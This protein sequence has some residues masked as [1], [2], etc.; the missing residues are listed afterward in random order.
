[1]ETNE[2][3]SN[4]EIRPVLRVDSLKKTFSIVELERLLSFQPNQ[5]FRSVEAVRNINL[6]VLPGEVFGFLGPNGAGKTTTI[7][8]CMDLI[9]PTEGHIQLFG[10]DPR[11][12]LAKEK[13]G[14]LPEHP[15]FYDYLKP[16]EILDY[17]GRVFGISRQDRKKKINELLDRVGLNHA[18]N[19]PLRKFSKGMLQRLGIAQAII[20]EPKL[21]VLDEPLSGLDPMGRKEIRDII[22]EQRSKGTTIFFSSHILSDIEHLCDRVAIVNHGEIVREGVLDTLLSSGQRQS[23]M[24]VRCEPN[25]LEK[26]LHF[27]EIDLVHLGSASRFVVDSEK[28]TSVIEAVHKAG[29]MIESLQP[30]R[31]SLEDLFVR[32]TGGGEA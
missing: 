16:Q 12:R 30:H 7:K 8:M 24:V 9:E 5:V 25:A 6:S 31:D 1:M 21:L 18:R 10:Q 17:F 3:S 15:Y 20:N 19:R 27:L 11:Q 13:V 14:Y 26:A 29:G 23:E 4:E 2:T 22:I 32:A 28:V